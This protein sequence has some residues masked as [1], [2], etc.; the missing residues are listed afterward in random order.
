M[1]A[2]EAFGLA[3]KASRVL[4]IWP[5]VLMY[6]D[7][8]ARKGKTEVYLPMDGIGD[9]DQLLS[10]LR[11]LGYTWRIEYHDYKTM[12]P[13]SKGVTIYWESPT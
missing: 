1:R 7:G 3:K 4:S 6:I 10:Y 11:D 5:T 2:N 13:P 9:D 8:A 12:N